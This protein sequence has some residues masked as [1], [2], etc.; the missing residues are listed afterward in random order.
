MIAARKLV[1]WIVVPVLI[2]IGIGLTLSITRKHRQVTLRGAVLRQDADPSKQVAI[3]DVN[4]TA[5]TGQT[6]SQAVSDKSGLFSVTL[7]R[8][9]RPREPVI[10]RFEHPDFHS[11]ELTGFIGDKLY[12]AR[13]KPINQPQPADHRPIHTIANVHLRYV[14]R[15]TE[16]VNV[17][18]AVKTFQVKNVGNVPCKQPDRCSPDG[19]WKAATASI[20]LDAGEGNAFRNVRASCIAGPCPFTRI[21]HPTVSDKGRQLRVTAEGWSDTTTFLVEAE[22][23]RLV[24]NEKV[25]QSYPVIFGPSLSFTLPGSAEGPSIEADVDGK[26]IVFPLPASLSLSWA[27]CTVGQDQENTLVYRCDLKPGYRFQ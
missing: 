16:T 10:L 17:G 21:D 18:S 11:L 2:A 27:Q 7:P 20:S 1:V 9:F 15:S 23:V 3:S 24:L 6:V 14:I 12:I 22:V 26:A 5:I 19:K 13:M 25:L 4:V 8:G